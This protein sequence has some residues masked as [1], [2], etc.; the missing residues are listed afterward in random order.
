MNLNGLRFLTLFS[1]LC[2]CSTSPLSNSH[3]N[4]HRSPSVEAG[5]KKIFRTDRTTFFDDFNGAPLRDPSAK[6]DP[7]FNKNLLCWKAF[8]G[9]SLCAPSVQS[10]LANLN[11][12]NWVV[13]QSR[14]TQDG[15]G[16]YWDTHHEDM[17]EVKNGFLYLNV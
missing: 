9:T 13:D 11:A 2:G 12:C 15:S 1:M 5:P 16:Q 10:K 14:G 8:N 4:V 17:I 3:S 6:A 7:C